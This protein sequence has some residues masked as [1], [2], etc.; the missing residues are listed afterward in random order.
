MLR[1]TQELDGSQSSAEGDPDMAKSDIGCRRRR[2]G[3]VAEAATFRLRCLTTSGST[4]YSDARVWAVNTGTL[5]ATL[6]LPI[7]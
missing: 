2:H 3:G 4:S 5:H 6:P 1:Q 7:D